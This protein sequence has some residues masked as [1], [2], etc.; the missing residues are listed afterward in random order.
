MKWAIKLDKRIEKQLK[1]LDKMQAQRILRFL[2]ERIA[3]L[4]NPRELGEALQGEHFSGLW[5]Y[6]VGDY[7]LITQ[8][9]D[10]EIQILVLKVGHR[11]EVYR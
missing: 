6:R 4:E 7:R 1:Q 2:F 9:K 3:T 11:R 8:I 10:E 5:K